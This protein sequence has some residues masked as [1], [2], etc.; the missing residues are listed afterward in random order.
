[1]ATFTIDT[2]NNITAFAEYEDALNHRIGS[3]EG[4]FA[5]EKELAK[6][7]SQWPIGRFIDAWNTFAG[8]VPFDA[9]KPVKKFT[10]RK[11]AVAR[12]W[13]AV[14][15]LTPAPA[16]HAAPVATKKA[17]AT[18]E[19]KP[20]GDA[21]GPKEAREGSKK[22]IVLDMLRRPEGATLADIQSATGWLAHSVRGF[23]SGGLSKKMG[24]KVE[25]FKSDGGDRAYRIAQ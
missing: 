21:A 6:L 2:E 10:D 17:K 3:T 11:T 20:K 24:I 12:I 13:K 9:L 7:T 18:K 15:A 23:I 1:M 14:Q 4:T 16:Q 22:A 19:A 25:S 8:V 5:S